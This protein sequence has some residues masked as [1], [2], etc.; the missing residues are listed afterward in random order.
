MVKKKKK[1]KKKRAPTLD[2]AW[3]PQKVWDGPAYIYIYIYI[4]T[5]SKLNA[6]L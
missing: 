2:L 3:G 6:Y 5:L 1:K 4:Y